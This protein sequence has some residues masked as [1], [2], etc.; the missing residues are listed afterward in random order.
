MKLEGKVAIVTG[1][2]SDIVRA[3]AQ[4]CAREDSKVAIADLDLHAANAAAAPCFPW[5]CRG[6]ISYVYS[7]TSSAG[8][9]HVYVDLKCARLA[10]R[11]RRTTRANAEWL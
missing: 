4:W 3:I 5:P 8:D 9:V 11:D 2:A 10:D 6:A 7:A 1:A